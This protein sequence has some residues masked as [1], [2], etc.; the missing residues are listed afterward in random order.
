MSSYRLHL[1]F[2]TDK[3]IVCVVLSNHAFVC[4][5]LLILFFSWPQ[6]MSTFHFLALCKNMSLFFAR[7][8][9]HQ[10]QCHCNNSYF[11][12]SKYFFLSF[13]FYTMSVVCGNKLNFV[14]TLCKVIQVILILLSDHSVLTLP[15]FSFV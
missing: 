10:H 7:N 6:M 2:S 14:I 3:F 4:V 8:I 1:K 15:P 11:H 13:I 12:S 9:V 5:F